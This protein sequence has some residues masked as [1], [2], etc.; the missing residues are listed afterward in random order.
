MPRKAVAKGTL[1]AQA[2]NS[3]AGVRANSHWNA[4]VRQASAAGPPGT[5]F[6][7]SATYTQLAAYTQSVDS[8]TDVSDESGLSLMLDE[9]Q[10]MSPE[11]RAHRQQYREKLRLRFEAMKPL[12][13]QAA[14][15]VTPPE[16]ATATVLTPEQE[17]AKDIVP[18]EFP[19]AEGLKLRLRRLST[20]TPTPTTKLN[21][22]NAR[23]S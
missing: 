2:G 7:S 17:A 23:P 6:T 21:S 16:S 22:T 10:D 1:I 11:Y 8:P 15:S 9:D 4:K 19:S 18:G 5:I 14:K 12:I 20:S 3:S 13:E